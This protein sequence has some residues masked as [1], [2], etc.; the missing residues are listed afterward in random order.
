MLLPQQS[1]LIKVHVDIAGRFS[2]SPFAI[3]VLASLRDSTLAGMVL[4]GDAALQLHT[5]SDALFVL[6]LGGFH[7]AFTP[8]AGFPTL[9]RLSLALPSNPLLQLS[10]SGYFAVTA[11]TLQF[12]ATLH[13]WAGIHDM[14]GVAGD[15]A[16]DALIS[17]DPLHF[18]AA[19]NVDIHVELAGQTLFGAKLKGAL[20]GPGPWHIQG[21]VY[22]E[23]M[24]WE[25][26]IYEVDHDFGATAAL[27]PP[28][29]VDP[30]SVLTTALAATSSWSANAPAT[31]VLIAPD[32][33]G[34]LV[35]SPAASLAV[36]QDRI[37]L[38]LLLDHIGAAPAGGTRMA[39]LGTASINALPTTT[40]TLTGSFAP[41]QF[42]DLSDQDAL[43]SPSF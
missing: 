19:L 32:T 40:T 37:P 31:A 39:T 14:L 27:P 6:A 42:L 9:R 11:N 30:A 41:A 13:F 21:G 10:L 43:S 1:P 25:A 8:P 38:G 23:V 24:W 17:W 2:A 29:A 34:A 22:V 26:K 20:S 36:T 5:G 7:P 3:D 12:G 4:S 15:A 28:A 33:T 16:F 35:V 18:Q